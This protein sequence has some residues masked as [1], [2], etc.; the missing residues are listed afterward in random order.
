MGRMDST[1]GFVLWCGDLR[2]VQLYAGWRSQAAGG[3]EAHCSTAQRDEGGQEQ[4]HPPPHRLSD[5]RR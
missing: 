1:S 5:P 2:N 3:P 4:E